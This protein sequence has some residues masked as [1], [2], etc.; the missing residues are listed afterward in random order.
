MPARYGSG[1]GHSASPT[2][3]PAATWSIPPPPPY[4]FLRTEVASG[5]PT[6]VPGES[7]ATLGVPQFPA[8]ASS[9]PLP[10][11]LAEARERLEAPPSAGPV[12]V[13]DTLAL[14]EAAP[15]GGPLELLRAGPPPAPEPA[16]D[17]V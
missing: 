10:D 7:A 13:A 8:L 2:E 16:A 17:G 4:A 14:I 15:A 1:A 5:G 6:L 11:W 9:P 3:G 12:P